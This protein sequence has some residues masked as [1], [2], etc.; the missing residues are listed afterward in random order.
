MGFWEGGRA[1]GGGCRR[2]A[3][4]L[5]GRAVRNRAIG[6]PGHLEGNLTL[7]MLTPA[8]E[9]ESFS[10][11]SD[12]LLA[13]SLPAGK[14]AVVFGALAFL[15]PPCCLAGL[16]PLRAALSFAALLG[17]VDLLLDPAGDRDA[18]GELAPVL[19]GDLERAPIS[20]GFQFPREPGHFKKAGAV[21]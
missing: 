13:D 1:V 10:L 18:R 7:L 12:L 5:P 19:F 3:R 17:V 16:L 6:R 4:P 9:D 15:P 14:A 2:V 21:S 11:L 8:I 20:P